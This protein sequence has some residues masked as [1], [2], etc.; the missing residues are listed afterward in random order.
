MTSTLC[1][2]IWNEPATYILSDTAAATRRWVGAS[3]RTRA[4]RTGHVL[5][6]PCA[7]LAARAADLRDQWHRRSGRRLPGGYYK[8]VSAGFV[9]FLAETGTKST[10][11]QTLEYVPEL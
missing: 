10:V 6:G 2:R 11:A 3:Q 1:A 4:L 5:R 9:L 7:R 8:R